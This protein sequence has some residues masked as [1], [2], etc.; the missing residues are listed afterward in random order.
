MSANKPGGGLTT[1]AET[2]RTPTGGQT[3]APVPATSTR[4]EP[5]NAAS[6]TTAPATP[7]SAPAQVDLER[8]NAEVRRLQT[9]EMRFLDEKRRADSL[10]TEVNRLREIE[11]QVRQL[12]D[13]NRELQARLQAAEQERDS[14]FQ[15]MRQAAGVDTGGATDTGA[16]G[17]VQN[18]PGGATTAST[19][20]LEG[21][22]TP[23]TSGAGGATGTSGGGPSTAST[24]N[25]AATGGGTAGGTSGAV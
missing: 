8:L 9:I 15:Q 12:D 10:E 17:G 1:S 18:A 6:A 3:P 25:S 20:G 5:T 4:L 14:M 24:A 23:S 13:A 21:A 11:P 16:S 19:G 22:G 2:N 7:V